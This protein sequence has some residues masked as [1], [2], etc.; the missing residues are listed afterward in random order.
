MAMK[1][2][3]GIKDYNMNA[4]MSDQPYWTDPKF[5]YDEGG[6]DRSIILE[7]LAMTPAE[8]LDALE[9]MLAFFEEVRRH[10]GGKSV[11]ESA[12]ISH[13]PSN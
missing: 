11:P 7:A 10:N 5:I 8:R 3:E 2:L 13:Q 6:Y 1:R 9:D 12:P 4:A